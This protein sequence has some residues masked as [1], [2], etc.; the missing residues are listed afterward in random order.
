MSELGLRDI[1]SGY[2]GGTFGEGRRTPASVARGLDVHRGATW[3]VSASA[4]SEYRLA[5]WKA[6][7]ACGRPKVWPLGGDR[8]GA[9]APSALRSPVEWLELRFDPGPPTTIVRVFETCA[10]GAVYAVAIDCGGGLEL[11]WLGAPDASL[12][13]GGQLLDVT[14]SEPRDVHAVRVYID[15]AQGWWVEI[16][17]VALVSADAPVLLPV[18]ASEPTSGGE[19]KARRYTRREI[20]GI[21]SLVASRGV[22]PIAARASSEWSPTGWSAE[23]IVG[24][25]NV[26]PKAGD[27]SGAW[28]PK[29]RTSDYEW[30]E[31]VFPPDTPPVR[32]VRVFETCAPGGAVE[33]RVGR[34]SELTSVWEGEREAL[35]VRQARVLEVDLAT[36]E[37]I[38]RV[39][40]RIDNSGDYWCEIDSVALLTT[41]RRRVEAELALAAA[42]RGRRSATLRERL[43]AGFDGAPVGRGAR[44]SFFDMMS[45]DWRARWRGTWPTSARASSSHGGSWGA[46]AATGSPGIY[47]LAGDLPGAWAP[48]EGGPKVDWLEVAFERDAKAEAIR[49]FET[50]GAGATFAVTLVHP[51]GESLIWKAAPEAASGARVLEIELPGLQP[52]EAVGVYVDN[53]VAGQPQIDSIGLIAG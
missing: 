51:A 15:N 36:C 43:L 16:D 18:D 5:S 13:T 29:Q 21:D 39:W 14:L 8:R 28:A 1:A 50:H 23:Q 3:P 12:G 30:I 37:P 49:I 17:T 31:A 48:A 25:P 53:T 52:V 45:R 32:A 6:A 10:P 47:P 34:G 44:H 40:V 4:S 24:R 7:Q 22:W 35:P 46:G 42:Y 27:H 38:E 26:W 19:A 2:P 41:P 11:A 33:L 9:W 20:E